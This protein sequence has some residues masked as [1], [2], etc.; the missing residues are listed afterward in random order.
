[1]V[2]QTFSVSFCITP[3]LLF[4]AQVVRFQTRV[5]TCN[6]SYSC[7]TT[8]SHHSARAPPILPLYKA[9]HLNSN[10]KGLRRWAGVS[11]STV[12][13]AGVSLVLCLFVVFSVI[14]L[15]ELSTTENNRLDYLSVGLPNTRNSIRKW[16][17]EHL[18]GIDITALDPPV[19]LHDLRYNQSNGRVVMNASTAIEYYQHQLRGSVWLKNSTSSLFKYAPF[20]GHSLAVA[21]TNAHGPVTTNSGSGQ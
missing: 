19:R 7:C 14:L 20:L 10:G 12:L 17:V 18:H 9:N 5:A 4:T 13:M 8:M 11:G 3:S 21:S 6:Q 1:V 2:T 15:R 16:S